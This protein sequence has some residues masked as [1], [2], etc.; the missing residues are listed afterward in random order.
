MSDTV[1]HIKLTLVKK[2]NITKTERNKPILMVESIHENFNNSTKCCICKK[3]YGE[4]E[5]KVADHHHVSGIK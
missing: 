5:M 3:A 4:G 2:M 1:K